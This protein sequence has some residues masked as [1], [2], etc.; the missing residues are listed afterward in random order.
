[1][2]ICLIDVDHS[3]NGQLMVQHEIDMAETALRVLCC[4]A[5]VTVISHRG[6]SVQ[7]Q[8]H[9]LLECKCVM[10]FFNDMHCAYFPH[11]SRK[12]IWFTVFA[13]RAFNSWCCH[14][15]FSTSVAQWFDRRICFIDKK[16]QG[17]NGPSITFARLT[18]AASS[19]RRPSWHF[20]CLFF[21]VGKCPTLDTILVYSEEEWIYFELCVEFSAPRE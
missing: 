15:L 9:S 13:L 17:L 7:R 11:E 8:H 14:S 2:Q 1:M 20:S 10:Y 5:M 6:A 12:L 21:L 3:Q 16:A 19:L 18:D 4:R